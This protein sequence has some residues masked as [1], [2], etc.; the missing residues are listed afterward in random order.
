[1][2]DCLRGPRDKSAFRCGNDAV[3]V[4]VPGLP[5]LRDDV[6][7]GIPRSI[8][9]LPDQKALESLAFVLDRSGTP[10]I[11][12]NHYHPF[13]QKWWT[14]CSLAEKVS[15]GMVPATLFGEKRTGNEE[16]E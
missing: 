16:T 14:R 5:G 4:S 10:F 6:L 11:P 9:C 8:L 7:A 1:M 12:R 13:F 2:A 3:V 15:R